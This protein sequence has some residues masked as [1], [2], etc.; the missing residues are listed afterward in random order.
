MVYWVRTKNVQNERSTPQKTILLTKYLQIEEREK[1]ITKP[2]IEH[3][4][5]KIKE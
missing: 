1:K 3:K 2:T 4:Q 5:I